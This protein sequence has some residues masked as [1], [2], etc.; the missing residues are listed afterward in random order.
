MRDAY[1]DGIGKGKST[2]DKLKS[3]LEFRSEILTREEYQQF[4]ELKAGTSNHVGPLPLISLGEI[5]GPL[6]HEIGI[7]GAI[8]YFSVA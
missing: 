1:E 6:I 2:T 5:Y 8:V 7:S 4:C 3:Q